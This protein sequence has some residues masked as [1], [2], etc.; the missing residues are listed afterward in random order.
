MDVH[1]KSMLLQWPGTVRALQKQKTGRKLNNLRKTQPRH[2]AN[3]FVFGC[4]RKQ[5]RPMTGET[6][7][8]KMG[9]VH[10]QEPWR[11][12]WKEHLGTIWAAISE[13]GANYNVDKSFPPA[14]RRAWAENLSLGWMEG[15]RGLRKR[16]HP[17]EKGIWCSSCWSLQ[18][19][20][21]STVTTGA[22][23]GL[24]RWPRGPRSWLQIQGDGLWLALWGRNGKQRSWG[25]LSQRY[26]PS[27]L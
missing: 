9:E 1:C 10:K 16:Q 23:D 2:K 26:V 24:S 15:R 14:A 18:G 12:L 8:N 27:V 5:P 4:R 3:S 17:A 25:H 7:H 6:Q 11:A 22:Q 20:F 13:T 21:S 19:M